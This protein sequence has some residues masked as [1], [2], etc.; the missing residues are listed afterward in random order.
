MRLNVVACYLSVTPGRGDGRYAWALWRDRCWWCSPCRQ[1]PAR[2]AACRG[3]VIPAAA[4]DTAGAQGWTQ[5]QTIA[6]YTTS[7]GSRLIPQAWFD[8]LEQPDAA[9]PF[10]DPTYIASFRYLPNPTAGWVGP[11]PSCPLDRALPLGFAVD[12]QSD[13]SLSITKLQWKTGQS[14]REP[15]VGMNCSACHTAVLG[16]KGTP[17]AHRGRA[18][19]ADFQSFTEALDRALQNTRTDPDKF[20]RFAAK[21]LGD[22]TPAGDADKLRAAMQSLSDWNAYI[23]R[24]NAAPI[25]YGYGRLDAIGHIFNKVAAVAMANSPANQIGNPADAP[26]SYPFLWNVPQQD[27]VEW[28]GLAANKKVGSG[29]QNDFDIGGLGRNTAK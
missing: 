8:A 21:V 13:T 19:L 20:K 3:T 5:A 1:S 28:N 11:D 14:D 4:A 2:A 23:A 9:A 12:C 26:V 25:R 16:Y 10:L 7:Q 15:W 22:N 17:V 6:W 24:L 18:T 29:P 27:R